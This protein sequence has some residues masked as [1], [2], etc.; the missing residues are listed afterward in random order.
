MAGCLFGM[1]NMTDLSL[2]LDITQGYAIAA[3]TPSIQGQM[4][5][6]TQD[7]GT[8]L[9]PDFEARMLDGDGFDGFFDPEVEGRL[10]ASA[11]YGLLYR[12]DD[13]G[14]TMT[15]IATYLQSRWAQ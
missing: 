9:K 1:E 6:G 2:G 15:N 4:L 10:Y 3:F 12:S 8:T 13:G 5:I 7:N 14:R 11:Y